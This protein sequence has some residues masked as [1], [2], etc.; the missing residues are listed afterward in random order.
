MQSL[1]ELKKVFSQRSIIIISL[2]PIIMTTVKQLTQGYDPDGL[3]ISQHYIKQI[4]ISSFRYMFFFQY[5]WKLY[6]DMF[7]HLH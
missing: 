6:G 3:I 1:V 5:L 2:K 4:H 7:R